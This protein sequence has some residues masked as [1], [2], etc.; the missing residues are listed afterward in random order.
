M[1]GDDIFSIDGIVPGGYIVNTRPIGLSLFANCRLPGK[2][3]WLVALFQGFAYE[4]CI[5]RT[6]G[7][8]AKTP[9]VFANAETRI[10]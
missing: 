7:A 8:S 3:Y 1:R 5:L 6:P 9:E 10:K 2:M 4:R